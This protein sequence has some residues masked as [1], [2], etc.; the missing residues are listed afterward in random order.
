MN[1]GFGMDANPYG[2]APDQG[3]GDGIWDFLRNRMAALRRGQERGTG[4]PQM[5][6]DIWSPIA[7]AGI[8]PGVP[9]PTKLSAPAAA[10]NP[11]VYTPEGAAYLKNYGQDQQAPDPASLQYAVDN[12]PMRAYNPSG[13]TRADRMGA[14]AP[15]PTGLG[16]GTAMYGIPKQLPPV[17]PVAGGGGFSPSQTDWNKVANPMAFTNY[18]EGI[19][20]A[21]LEAERRQSQTAQQNPL[22]KEQGVIGA[23]EGAQGRLME[24]QSSLAEAAQEAMI[25][26][27]V[28]AARRGAM[29]GLVRDPKYMNGTPEI[30]GRMEEEAKAQAESDIRM[31][32]SGGHTNY[33]MSPTL[34]R[35]F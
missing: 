25:R 31:K 14:G 8:R 18:G 9:L 26:P 22:W 7:G 24:K 2:V 32:M 29:A 28:E 15:P 17:P 34:S 3:G 30:R 10:T 19:Q 21:A 12:G 35:V 16:A 4:G 23:Q 20:Q 33:N 11:N 27:A 13:D 5:T 6:G 1:Y